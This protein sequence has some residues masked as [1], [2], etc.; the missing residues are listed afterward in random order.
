MTAFFRLSVGAEHETSPLRDFLNRYVKIMCCWSEIF[1][2][3]KKIANRQ[4]SKVSIK[5]AATSGLD[6]F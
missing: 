6:S 1:W 4:H 5:K 3:F 2:S